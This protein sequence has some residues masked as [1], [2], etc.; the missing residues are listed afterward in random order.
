MG[1]DDGGFIVTWH[2]SGE[3]ASNDVYAQ[4]YNAAGEVVGDAFRLNDYVGNNQ[5]GAQLAQL[6]DGRIVAAWHSVVRMVAAAV[7]TEKS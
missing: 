6:A 3:G 4:R 1:L 2:S 5:D 7:F